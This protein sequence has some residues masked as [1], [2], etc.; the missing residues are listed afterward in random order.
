MFDTRPFTET[1]SEFNCTISGDLLHYRHGSDVLVVCLSPKHPALSSKI[2][3][4]NF[5]KTHKTKSGNKSHKVV[6]D[7]K[8]C[9]ILTEDEK[10][11]IIRFEQTALLLETN[12]RLISN[13]ELLNKSP[14]Y[15]GFLVILQ[16]YEGPKKPT[17]F[18]EL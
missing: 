11:Y 2:K 16:L 12:L 9:E 6:K 14:T 17:V 18:K 5:F 7:E 13:P 1:E 4:V 15:E 3:S 8:I 10:S